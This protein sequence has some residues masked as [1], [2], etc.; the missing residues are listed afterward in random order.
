MIL[1]FFFHWGLD[2]VCRP[3]E[4]ISN[5][6]TTTWKFYSLPDCVSDHFS[7]GKCLCKSPCW[8]WA[9]AGLFPSG[10]TLCWSWG[11]FLAALVGCLMGRDAAAQS[12]TSSEPTSTLGR[13]PGEM[14][15]KFQYFWIPSGLV[16]NTVL[17][18][19]FCRKEFS[20]LIPVQ[21]ISPWNHS[22]VNDIHEIPKTSKKMIIW[23]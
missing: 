22:W 14:H 11:H 18:D 23:D 8:D 19:F 7:F 9:S 16:R 4:I 5:I 3:E 6:F 20:H 10:S 12:L 2:P 1:T 17:R 15:L 13:K 21:G